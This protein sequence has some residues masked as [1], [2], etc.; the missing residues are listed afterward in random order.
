MTVIK[1][2]RG[3]T[4]PSTSNLQSFEIGFNKTANDLY[5]N[6]NG[7]ITRLGIK[8]LTGTSAPASGTG[9]NNDIYV[10]YSTSGNDTTIDSFFVK[11]SG[12]W[13]ALPAGGASVLMGTTDPTAA[14]GEDGNLYVKY[15]TESNVPVVDAF[16]V[17]ISGAWASV[18]TSGGAVYLELTQV[19]YDALSTAE[20]NNGTIYF[21]T[22]GVP[23]IPKGVFVGTCS[24]AAAT[25]AKE[26]VVSADQNFVLE[27]GVVVAVKFVN[28]NTAYNVTISVNGGMAYPIYYNVAQ[29]TSNS[30][31]VTGYANTIIY[32]M[33]DG[34]YWCW[35]NINKFSSYS[36]MSLA[37]AEAGTATNGR[38][39]QATV[40][41]DAIKYHALHGIY[42]GTCSTAGETAAKQVTVDSS[43]NFKLEVGT[44]IAVKYSN[45]SASGAGGITISVNSGTAYP[46]WYDGA[47]YTDD[48]PRVCG[49]PDHYIVYTFDGSY[50]VWVS[51]DNEIDYS[52]MTNA[53]AEDGTGS[54]AQTISPSTLK[55][56][57]QY[58]AI[59]QVNGTERIVGKLGNDTL[60][61]KVYVFSRSDM[62][63]GSQSNSR[64]TGVFVLDDINYDKIMLTDGQLINGDPD[65]SL[66]VLSMPLPIASTNNV[67]CRVQIQK[68][69]PADP[70]T[71]PSYDG[72]PFVYFDCTYNASLI[73]PKLNSMTWVFTVRYTK[74]SS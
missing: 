8:V 62:Q 18:S 53:Q 16:F 15:H 33:W 44:T 12:A 55:H 71:P 20:K 45:M 3:D 19:Q 28:T 30:T 54:N 50:W 24:T 60:Y 22:D 29:Y 47:Q 38:S 17:K 26:V 32:Y 72:L 2:K 31:S 65:S 58:H 43:Q 51:C 42:V 52:N 57:V 61:E 9:T 23:T 25:A 7:T 46:V 70:S 36:A 1:I 56:A 14:M 41:K 21:V 5:I 74:L 73:N 64:I 63:G 34:T 10:Q 6:N 13:V 11:L 67:Y 69:I 37:E 39:I 59:P 48:R 27:K 35:Y 49:Y 40:L 4:V 68:S 66:S